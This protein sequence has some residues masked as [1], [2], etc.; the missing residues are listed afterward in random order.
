M[1]TGDLTIVI[2]EN[3]LKELIQSYCQNPDPKTMEAI[4]EMFL[5]LEDA[6]GGSGAKGKRGRYESG[7]K[8]H[9]T[10][11]IPNK[12]RELSKANDP[13]DREFISGELLKLLAEV[14]DDEK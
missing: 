8:P 2:D 12:L 6:L 3:C 11:E 4:D 5:P 13:D 9:I 1:K 10:N 7:L 14:K